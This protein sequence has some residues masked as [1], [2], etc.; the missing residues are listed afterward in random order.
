MRRTRK[1]I[2]HVIAHEYCGVKWAYVV[3]FKD[4]NMI[5]PAKYMN[6]NCHKEYTKLPKY[7][8][9]FIQDARLTSVETYYHGTTVIKRYEAA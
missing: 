8:K 3:F 7:I 4:G 9:D 6:M 5:Y 1:D 2:A